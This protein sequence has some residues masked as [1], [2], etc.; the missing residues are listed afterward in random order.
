MHSSQHS[1]LCFILTSFAECH[2]L[3]ATHCQAVDVLPLQLQQGEGEGCPAAAQGVL[4]LELAIFS[5]L[6]C[7]KT[8]SPLPAEQRQFRRTSSVRLRLRAMGYLC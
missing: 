1:V 3:G 7:S 4:R 5:V 6:C 8:G 2:P